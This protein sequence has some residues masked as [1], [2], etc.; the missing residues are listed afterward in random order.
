MTS[1]VLRLL[2]DLQDRDGV[3]KLRSADHLFSF[4]FDLVAYEEDEETVRDR[5][6]A[7]LF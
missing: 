3:F 4:F 6:W 7:G 5:K 1:P 2:T